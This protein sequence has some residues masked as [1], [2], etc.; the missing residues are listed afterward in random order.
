MKRIYF[1]LITIFAFSFVLSSCSSGSIILPADSLLSPPL[2]YEE[3]E[4]KHT[5]M[6]RE[7]EIKRLSHSEKDNLRQEWEQKQEKNNRK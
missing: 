5:A 4:D 3:Y 7:W 2:Y 1:I 6:R